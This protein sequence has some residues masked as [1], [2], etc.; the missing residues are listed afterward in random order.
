MSDCRDIPSGT[1]VGMSPGMMSSYEMTTLG[2]MRWD[3]LAKVGCRR[4]EHVRIQPGIGTRTLESAG[5]ILHSY[6]LLYSITHFRVRL[7]H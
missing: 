3:A 6:R 7:R 5:N 1:L 4:R 2:G